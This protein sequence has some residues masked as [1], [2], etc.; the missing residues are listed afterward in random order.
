[1]KVAFT[2]QGDSEQARMDDRFGRA[3]YFVIVDTETQ[4][5]EG[6]SNPSLSAGS[7]AGVQSADFLSR[8]GVQAVVTGNVGPNGAH[9]LGAA[10]IDIYQSDYATVA[11][12]L[13]ALKKGSLQKVDQPTTG[14]G[15]GKRRNRRF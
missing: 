8:R 10:G 7:G 2:A 14:S 15:R 12:N 5:S 9:A 4:A 1:M 3:S 13:R 6:V 11:E